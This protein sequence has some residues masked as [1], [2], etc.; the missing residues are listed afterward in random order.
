MEGLTIVIY[1]V[2]DHIH[3]LF[4]LSKN[5]ALAKVITDLNPFKK[6]NK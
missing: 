2:E 1:F 4:R 3:I 5:Q 6:N